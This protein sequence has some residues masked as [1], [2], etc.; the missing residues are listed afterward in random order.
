MEE[1]YLLF[2]VY[3]PH[4]S[5]YGIE[6]KNMQNKKDIK[7]NDTA[8]RRGKIILNKL[9]KLKLIDLDKKEKNPRKRKS[10]FLTDRGLF[11]IMRLPTFLSIDI[12]SMIRNYPNFRIFKEFL[13]PFIKLDSLCST[14]IPIGTLN[15]ISLHL[16]KQYL[17]IENF[18]FNNK[19]RQDWNEDRWMW[20]REK[21]RKYLIEKYNYKWLENADVEEN[22]EKMNIIYFNNNNELTDYIEVRL[23]GDKTS[24]YLINGSKK[25]KKE[26]ISTNI[27]KFLI[28]WSFSEEECIGRAFSTL[29]NVTSSEFIFS[30]LSTFH[31]FDI[32]SLLIFSKD[33]KF[34]RSLEIAKGDFNKI[35][36]SIKNPYEYSIE[37]RLAKNFIETF[38]PREIKR[39]NNILNS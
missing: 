3:Y 29:Y 32:D 10:Y 16:Q 38:L 22:Y 5:A 15:T 1:S 35:Y 14:N 37:S 30:I 28:K 8:Y 11:Y 26:E 13:Y 18:I 4:Y 23:R 9:Y 27:K 24:G 39:I 36:L 6:K 31:S 2:F 20:N 19:N 12:Q 25:N 17:K 21:L 7:I 34:L 33:E